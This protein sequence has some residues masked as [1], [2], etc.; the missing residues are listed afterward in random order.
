MVNCVAMVGQGV[1]AGFTL[2]AF[3]SALGTF[4]LVGGL[5]GGFL[6]FT[7][8]TAFLLNYFIGLFNSLRDSLTDYASSFLIGYRGKKKCRP[9]LFC[10]GSCMPSHRAHTASAPLAPSCIHSCAIRR[11]LTRPRS[12]ICGTV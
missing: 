3:H 4:R 2:F 7:V 8:P 1:F 5:F 6:C 10:G 11:C 9:G 12:S